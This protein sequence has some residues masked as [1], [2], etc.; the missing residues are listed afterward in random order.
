MSK[1]KRGSDIDMA[2]QKIIAEMEADVENKNHHIEYRIGLAFAIQK[3][4]LLR[5]D[6]IEDPRITIE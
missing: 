6:Y 4:A 1:P 5:L 2:I 3:L